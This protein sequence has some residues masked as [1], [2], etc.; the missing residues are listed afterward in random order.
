MK[1][2]SAQNPIGV[3]EVIGTENSYSS[4][5]IDDTTDQGDYISHIR[6]QLI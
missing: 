5:L 1:N 6:L 4:L 3:E 2:A